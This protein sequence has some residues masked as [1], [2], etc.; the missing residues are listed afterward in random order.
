[1]KLCNIESE[2]KFQALHFLLYN[3]GLM[4]FLM[5]SSDLKIRAGPPPYRSYHFLVTP[6]QY[7]QLISSVHLAARYIWDYFSYIS[8]KANVNLIRQ[9]KI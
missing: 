2:T 3:R 6:S 8:S 9:M 4:I 7:T 1:M 5:P